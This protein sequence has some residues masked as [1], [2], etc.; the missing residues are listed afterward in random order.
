MQYSITI[1]TARVL[2]ELFKI[3]DTI[4]ALETKAATAKASAERTAAA[5]AI[6]N[7]PTALWEQYRALTDQREKR[8]FYLAHQSV[9]DR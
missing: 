5:V 7:T 8:T 6:A 1:T 4:R 2:D 9:L 3:E